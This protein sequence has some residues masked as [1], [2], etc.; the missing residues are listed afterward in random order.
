MLKFS[1]RIKQIWQI[2]NKKLDFRSQINVKIT[3][4]QTGHQAGS[5]N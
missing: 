5:P 3:P 2:C 4:H 1:S